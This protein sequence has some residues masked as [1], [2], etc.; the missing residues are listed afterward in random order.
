MPCSWN[1][2]PWSAVTTTMVESR[3]P[4]AVSPSRSRSS[5]TP[6]SGCRRRRG[7][8]GAAPRRR[9]AAAHP[10]SSS[11]HRPAIDARPGDVTAH[12][13][14][15]A[16]SP[17][18]APR[19]PSRFRP[20]IPGLVRQ[21]RDEGARAIAPSRV[22]APRR[23]ALH[24][25]RAPAGDRVRPLV[26]ACVGSRRAQTGTNAATAAIRLAP[27]RHGLA[28]VDHAKTVLAAHAN[29]AR[30]DT[31]QLGTARGWRAAGGTRQRQGPFLSLL[32]DRHDHSDPAP[33]ANPGTAVAPATAAPKGTLAI[34]LAV[35][36]R[37]I[38]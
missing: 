23:D 4:S 12:T 11:D 31:A 28:R 24:A 14:E 7:S 19:A 6:R 18:A 27:G 9:R 30:A 26:P 15:C 16:A 29:L 1:S 5:S 25:L 33:D 32:T 10:T 36:A 35:H 38:G 21:V 8:G 37:K 20:A 17:A 2:S 22:K 34:R 13:R 3:T